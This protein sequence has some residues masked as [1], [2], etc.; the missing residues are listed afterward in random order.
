MNA[1]HTSRIYCFPELDSVPIDSL[2]Y[3]PATICMGKKAEFVVGS[4][5]VM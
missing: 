4:D 1:N 3:L 2:R 5:P